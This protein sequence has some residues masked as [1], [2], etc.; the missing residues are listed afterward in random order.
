MLVVAF[1]HTFIVVPQSK[2]EVA[3]KTVL[4]E[5]TGALKMVINKRMLFMDMQILWTGFSISFWSSLLL[6]AV[7][8]EVDHTKVIDHTDSAAKTSKGLMAL[9]LFGVGEISGGLVMG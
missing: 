6:P 9:V 4:Q 1:A 7:V 3:H 5:L 2:E 8:L